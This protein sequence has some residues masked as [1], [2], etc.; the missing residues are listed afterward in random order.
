MYTYA[1]LYSTVKQKLNGNFFN[2]NKPHVMINYGSLQGTEN[3]HSM[4]LQWWQALSGLHNP[5]SQREESLGIL[6]FQHLWFPG[7]LSQVYET[8]QKG[9]KL[10][11]CSHYRVRGLS[12][13][14][15]QSH[16][17]V[18]EENG[19]FSPFLLRDPWH[20][21]YKEQVVTY[22]EWEHMAIKIQSVLT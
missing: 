4:G 6:W 5:H 3:K 19:P 17:P 11:S 8:S 10:Q 18:L 1:L 9:W 12:L 14:A 7:N 2:A 20:A 13:C 21:V 16:V 15:R 22:K